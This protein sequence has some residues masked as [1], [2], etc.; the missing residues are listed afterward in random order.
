MGTEGRVVTI[1]V[2]ILCSRLRTLPTGMK[3]RLALGRAGAHAAAMRIT[4]EALDEFIELYKEEFGEEISRSEASEMA[5]RLVTL[6]GALVRG[7]PIR[8][9][10]EQQSDH[11]ASRPVG[12]RV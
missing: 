4:D 12:F 11:L 2:S 7:L 1:G 10:T 9:P 8:S 3:S 5:F 6:Y